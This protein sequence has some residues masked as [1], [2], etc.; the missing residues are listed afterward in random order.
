VIDAENA[1][2][3]RRS[4]TDGTNLEKG[5]SKHYGDLFHGVDFRPS[6]PQGLKPAN[7]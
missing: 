3:L 4:L 1:R 7:F 5:E 2:P 6:E